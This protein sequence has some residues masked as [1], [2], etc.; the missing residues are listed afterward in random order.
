ML[1][2]WINIVGTFSLYSGKRNVI[3]LSSPLPYSPVEPFQFSEV[4]RDPAERSSVMN[5]VLEMPASMTWDAGLHYSSAHPDSGFPGPSDSLLPE[6]QHLNF[7]VSSISCCIFFFCGLQVA[8]RN[9]LNIPAT[10][11]S[12]PYHWLTLNWLYLFPSCNELRNI[13]SGE[14]HQSEIIRHTIN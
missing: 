3:F 7:N 9:L 12:T 11:L 2:F 6:R 4:E 8:F 1:L 10:Q 5:V 13:W 14:E